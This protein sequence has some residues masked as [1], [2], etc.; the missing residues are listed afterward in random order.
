MCILLRQRPPHSSAELAG[1]AHNQL[2][3]LA[4]STDDGLGA[5]YHYYLG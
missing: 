1:N 3:V 2:A 5:L 4:T